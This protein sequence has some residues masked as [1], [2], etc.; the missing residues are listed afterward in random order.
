MKKK[1]RFVKFTNNYFFVFVRIV[2]YERLTIAIKRIIIN[3]YA[4]GITIYEE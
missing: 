4:L 1:A 2:I 3:M